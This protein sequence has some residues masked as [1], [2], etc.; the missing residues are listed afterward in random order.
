LDG[1]L[2]FPASIVSAVEQRQD[3]LGWLGI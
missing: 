3:F 2:C 1:A